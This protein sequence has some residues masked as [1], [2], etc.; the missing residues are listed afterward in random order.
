VVSGPTTHAGASSN[1]SG[2][3]SATMVDASVLSPLLR[4]YADQ[5][6]EQL[7]KKIFSRLE[8]TIKQGAASVRRSPRLNRDDPKSVVIDKARASITELVEHNLRK[9]QQ[10]VEQTAS[11]ALRRSIGGTIIEDDDKENSTR[12]EEDSPLTRTLTPCGASVETPT[13]PPSN[14]QQK[15][16]SMSLAEMT[17]AMG[18]DPDSPGMVD[19]FNDSPT[20]KPPP[21]E[22]R[23]RSS[24]RTTMLAP[25][26]T[27]SIRESMVS[28]KE[29]LGAASRRRSVR[30][31]KNSTSAGPESEGSNSRKSDFKQP[32]QVSKNWKVANQDDHNK[33]L[34]RL[35]NSAN[36]K[37]LQSLPTVGPKTAYLIHSHR[38]LHNGFDSFED[39]KNVPGLQKN[40]FDK[41]VKVHQIVLPGEEA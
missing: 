15:T 13:K 7:E 34:L 24:R 32:L 19:M 4:K 26:L 38:E 40:F 31:A 37:M 29:L 3:V 30:I 1:L 21:P 11:P 35:L 22:N 20:K 5:L 9:H 27:K 8:E 41:F 23:K 6:T 25:E 39:L 12:M 36:L 18:I 14:S 33:S 16:P 10:R 28:N 2:T 17:M